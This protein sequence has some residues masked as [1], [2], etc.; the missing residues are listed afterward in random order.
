MSWHYFF[1]R[2]TTKGLRIKAATSVKWSIRND[3]FWRHEFERNPWSK[4]WEKSSKWELRFRPSINLSLRLKLDFIKQITTFTVCHYSFDRLK[5]IMASIDLPDC[6]AR[7]RKRPQKRNSLGET[8]VA[9]S[10]K[11]KKSSSNSGRENNFCWSSNQIMCL[12]QQT[13]KESWNL[14]SR[15]SK[16]SLPRYL[17]IRELTLS[18]KSILNVG[19]LVFYL[20]FLA[21]LKNM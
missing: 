14:K 15:L 3:L 16:T 20:I 10:P 13:W 9:D 18:T 19:N 2:F 21:G 1:S 6:K 11:H 7:T 4:S 12:F 17:S 5:S 8:I